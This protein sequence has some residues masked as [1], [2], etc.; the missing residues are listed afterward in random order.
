MGGSKPHKP[1]NEVWINVYADY[2]KSAYYNSKYNA[3]YM[4]NKEKV[5]VYRLHVK[6]KNVQ[7]AD[8]LE[9]F[10]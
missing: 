9:L 10:K 6:K 3:K 7:I 8:E 2:S 1:A 4:I 5:L